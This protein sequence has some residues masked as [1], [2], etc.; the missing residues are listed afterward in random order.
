VNLTE[1]RAHISETLTSALPGIRVYPH[2]PASVRAND[3][4]LILR[5]VAPAT[6]GT[7]AATVDVLVVIGTDEQHAAES[8]DRLSVALITAIGGHLGAPITV[9]PQTVTADGADLFCATASL[10]IEVD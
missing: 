2:R 9:V 4:W 7:C 10:L 6:F 1:T 8:L 3:G 5:S